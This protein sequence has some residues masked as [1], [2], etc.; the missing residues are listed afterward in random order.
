MD[1]PSNPARVVAVHPGAQRCLD[2]SLRGPVDGVLRLA[3]PAGK[4][5]GRLEAA[6]LQ[7]Q[8][9]LHLARGA[10][11]LQELSRLHP[12]GPAEA[13]G[14]R[15]SAGPRAALDEAPAGRV[16]AAKN[17]AAMIS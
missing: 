8:V 5:D 2:R 17:S 15:N 9:G 3:S 16:M 6:L 14:G 7:V 11:E 10:R 12:R 1:W 4:I 13:P